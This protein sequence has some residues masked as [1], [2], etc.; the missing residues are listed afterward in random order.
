MQERINFS[1]YKKYHSDYIN[2]STGDTTQD[3]T[4]SIVHLPTGMYE[5]L[6]LYRALVPC[7][8]ASKPGIRKMQHQD[9]SAFSR[10][11]IVFLERDAAVESP[12][13]VSLHLMTSGDVEV[14]PGPSRDAPR[15]TRRSTRA[16]C[17]PQA[18]QQPLSAPAPNPQSMEPDGYLPHPSPPSSRTRSRLANKTLANIQA[19]LQNQA[20]ANPQPIQH[21]RDSTGGI[22]STGQET[23][24][25]TTEETRPNNS[26]SQHQP[27]APVTNLAAPRGTRAARPKTMT[28]KTMK[29]RA[30]F[31]AREA[32]WC[33]GCSRKKKCVRFPDSAPAAVPTTTSAAAPTAAPAPVAAPAPMA[34]PTP[35]PT[36]TSAPTPA[37]PNWM[38]DPSDLDLDLPISSFDD[39]DDAE[40]FFL[41]QDLRAT[42]PS[43]TREFCPDDAP[44][45]SNH[46]AQ[47]T[48]PVTAPVPVAATTPMPAPIPAP[49]PAQP[50]WMPDPS[51]LELDLPI[52]S[53][54]DNDDAEWFYQS[55]D[56][57]ATQT[58][59]TRE[60]C[61][62]DA[63]TV[64]NYP[65]QATGTQGPQDADD[66]CAQCGNPFMATS[67]PITCGT[68]SKNFCKSKEECT[69]MNRWNLSRAM[70]SGMHFACTTCKGKPPTPARGTRMHPSTDDVP[71]GK[72]AAGKCRLQIK[73]RTDFLIC[74]GCNSH[75]HKHIKCSEMSREQVV[76]L[77][78]RQTWKCPNCE[79]AEDYLNNRPANDPRANFKFKKAAPTKLKILQLNI[80]AISA[81]KQELKGFLKK[82]DISIALIQETKMITKDRDP[83]LPGYTIIRKDRPQPKGKERNRGGGLLMA[84]KNDLNG[85]GYKAVNLTVT[86]PADT[87]TESQT[88]EI[89]TGDQHNLRL[90]NIYIPPSRDDPTRE[91]AIS[92][93]EWPHTPSDII[94][95]DINA[96]SPSWENSFSNDVM[97]SR[98]K[99]FEK[100][101][102]DTGMTPLN[103]GTHTHTCKRSGTATLSAPDVAFANPRMLEKLEWETVNDL[104]SDHLP[105]IITYTTTTPHA[106]TIPSYRFKFEDA[107][108]SAYTAQVEKNLPKLY[109]NDPP[110]KVEK[111][112]RRVILRAAYDNI[113]TKKTT[114]NTKCWFTK[115]IKEAI[116]K[117]NELRKQ[118]G[119]TTCDAFVEATA[120]AA[121][122]IHTTKEERWKE[123]LATIDKSTDSR[124]I[125]RTIRAMDGRAP[126]QKKN[127]V[128]TVDGIDYVDDKDKAEQFAK[129]YRSFSKLP[130]LKSDRP[131]R[132]KNRKLGKRPLGT[133]ESEMPLTMEEL[134]RAIGQAG[135]SKAPG[136]DRIPYELI[137]NLGP[138][139]R[140]HLLHLFNLCWSGTG[141]PGNWL[142]AIIKP[143]LKEGKDPKLPESY[144]PISLLSCMGKLLEKVIADRLLHVLEKG[145]LLNEC[146]AG[147]RP[148]RT[149]TDQILKFVQ[150]ASD[151]LHTEER[152]R[153]LI[154]TFFDYEKAFDKVWRD[155]LIHKLHQLN[156]PPRFIRYVRS[157]LAGRKTRVEVNGTRSDQFFLKQGLPQGSSISPILFVIYINDIDVDLDPQTTASLF[158]DDTATWLKDGHPRGSNT[159]LAQEEIDKIVHWADTWKMAINTDKTRTMVTST[160]LDDLTWNPLLTASGS[161]IANVPDYKFLGLVVTN[162]LLFTKHIDYI[163]TK[164]RK[165]VNIL[166]CLATKSWGCSLETQRKLYTQY[167]RSALEYAST[168]FHGWISDTHMKRLQRIQNAAMRAIA[169]LAKT[170]PVDFLHL[171]TGLEPLK[172]RFEKNDDIIWDRYERLPPTDPRNQ[173]IN[174]QP[175]IRLATRE[176]FRAKTRR[177]F[178]FHSITRDV[179]TPHLEPWLRLAN[180]TFASV[181]LS[182]RKDQYTKEELKKLTIDKINS[183]GIDTHIFTDG[184]TDSNQQ[185]GGAGL[186][187]KTADGTPLHEECRAAGALCSSY[188]GECVALLMACEWLERQPSPANYLICTDSK[189]LLDALQT[190]SWTDPDPWL[191]QVKR[192]IAE[193][194]S[195]ITLLWMPSHCDV[196]GNEQADK[197]A[198]S[199]AKMDQSQVPIPHSIVKAKIRARTWKVTHPEAIKIYGERTSPRWEIERQ[200]PM[201]VRSLFSRLRTGHSK[202]LRDYSFIIEKDD[203]DECQNCPLQVPETIS[204]VL[205]ICPALAQERTELAEGQVTLKML[206]TDPET[207]RCILLKRFPGLRLPEERPIEPTP[208]DLDRPRTPITTTCTDAQTTSTMRA[209]QSTNLPSEANQSTSAHPS[210]HLSAHPSAHLSAQLSAQPSA[211]VSAHPSAHP[212]ANLN[213]HPSAQPSAQPSA[214][215]STHLSTHPSADLNAPPPPS[216]PHPPPPRTRHRANATP[217]GSHR[218]AAPPRTCHRATATQRTSHPTTPSRPTRHR[219]TAP[220]RDSPRVAA[221]SPPMPASNLQ[222]AAPPRSP[223]PQTGQKTA[224]PPPAQADREPTHSSQVVLSTNLSNAERMFITNC[225]EE[226]D[227]N[228]TTKAMGLIMKDV[229]HLSIQP[230]SLSSL[231]EELRYSEED[232]IFIHHIESQHHFVMSASLGGVVW[233]FD[234]LN[235]T[236]SHLLERQVEAIYQPRDPS[237]PRRRVLHPTM[238]HTQVGSTDCGVY[239]IAYAVEVALGT[240]PGELPTIS[241][242]RHQMRRH[243]L[244]IFHTQRVA[245]F[246]RSPTTRL[247]RGSAPRAIGCP[248]TTTTSSRRADTARHSRRGRPPGRPSGK[249]PA[250][251]GSTNAACQPT[252]P[253]IPRTR[254]VNQPASTRA[255]QQPPATTPE[256]PQPPE[257]PPP[258]IPDVQEPRE[259]PDPPDP[260]D[261]Q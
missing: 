104:S 85:T 25:L 259:P 238:D 242:Q 63:P 9:A 102:E 24:A 231:P 70:R 66:H 176:G 175:P 174:A 43:L 185:C 204:H 207:C 113:S 132:K 228:V 50:N 248:A 225:R 40:W 62:D 47:D 20:T 2:N 190:N 214:D 198:N 253:R 186:F 220:A 1:L 212:S 120:E 121:K 261:H 127:A 251:P 241:Y 168:S 23:A 210:A 158:A 35:A 101:M 141:L 36:P 172:L 182:K 45:D 249:A 74:S 81:K 13:T 245:R 205:C 179:T 145:N 110:N 194:P 201:D 56:L 129:T 37:Q 89:P 139:A 21:I 171:E 184:S 167:I 213:A 57:R 125:W 183:L 72:C 96:H 227:D 131:L 95:G 94:L 200:W 144:R 86:A 46:P 31:P 170:C 216:P 169:G 203:D 148:G 237:Q 32:E 160:V 58:S 153:R 256:D 78:D 17:H 138:K 124:K 260:P 61:P 236:P 19:D 5:Y 119:D 189:S 16:A 209:N 146:Q 157:F 107:D 64:S 208:P 6:Y 196:H 192:K 111:K 252:S 154:T 88:I 79:S 34:A 128:L 136:D 217:R 77:G 33:P 223:P 239:A 51:D 234:S 166:R 143:Q 28:E 150:E 49:A 164:C 100:W 163:I 219:E 258:E 92:L 187:I 135:N 93:D 99:K 53:F 71:P 75:W 193:L 52:S 177:T 4:C 235:L 73:S 67:K 54:D 230:T 152:S 180:L 255:V 69:G 215:L 156:V 116:R 60:F 118:V 137:K 140:E 27:G 149:T 257:P 83:K 147:F 159:K 224:P 15:P 155:G 243:L 221:S 91:A 211:D 117:R 151:Q 126:P 84:I 222:T 115:E 38:L 59:L 142:T 65:A 55:Q 226:L 3:H 233:T 30:T 173:M 97:D 178:P 247:A 244:D 161:A 8:S 250:T 246:P 18:V 80:D 199:G 42:Q 26:R 232:T 12:D 254:S 218:T 133:E 114:P 197:L 122:L 14:N 98:G 48:A 82:H 90:T 195:N 39:N 191:K 206:V 41:S 188:T 103:S 123:Y 7:A 11:A 29:C 76:A 202:E 108:W 134:N 181:P 130:A 229:A 87:L 22:A 162:D 105:I 112:F 240:D 165:R 10:C 68:C 44:T 109:R 106:N